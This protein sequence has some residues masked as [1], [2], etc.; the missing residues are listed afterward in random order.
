[1]NTNGLSD[2]GAY[3]LRFLFFVAAIL[4]FSIALMLI[5]ISFPI[6]LAANFRTGSTLAGAW[7][8]TL[9]DYGLRS[10]RS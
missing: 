7:A 2:F 3:V 4:A 1:M 9:E 5:A 6:A 10:G 8:D